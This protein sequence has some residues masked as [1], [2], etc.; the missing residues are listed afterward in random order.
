M[1]NPQ[2]QFIA[3]SD[4]LDREDMA[5]MLRLSAEYTATLLALAMNDET[6]A[7]PTPR[8]IEE[9]NYLVSEQ[10]GIAKR[11]SNRVA[12]QCGTPINCA[13]CQGAGLDEVSDWRMSD[14]K[15]G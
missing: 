11:L 3:S 12:P 2:N 5:D 15:W 14:Q 10:L 8:L 13:S 9:V 6:D 4:G 7:K 1:Q